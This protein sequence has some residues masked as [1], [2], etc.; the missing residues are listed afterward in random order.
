MALYEIQK[1]GSPVLREKANPIEKVDETICRLLD[2]MVETM[3]DSDGVGLAAP[4]IGV[5]KRA[6]VV[7]AGGGLIELINPVCV[8]SR[9]NDLAEEGCLSIPGVWGPVPRAKSVTIEG[10]D[11][12]GR[13]VV[14]KAK[15]YTARA[16]QH[17]IDHLDGVLFTDKMIRVDG[18]EQ[19]Q[20]E[21]AE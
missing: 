11:R 9:G 3:Y 10:L 18:P 12:Q 5:S 16:L 2:D 4:Q 7:D 14:V 15:D 13:K 20:K 21:Q 8:K 1:V 19:D 6:I 17:E